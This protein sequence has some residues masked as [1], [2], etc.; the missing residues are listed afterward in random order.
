M[1][2][3]QA[4]KFNNWVIPFDNRSDAFNLPLRGS[5]IQPFRTDGGLSV[6]G[7]RRRPTAEKT[8][9]VTFDLKDTGQLIC[10]PTFN[11][12]ASPK[13][14]AMMEALLDGMGRL[15]FDN[16]AKSGPQVFSLAD[17]NEVSVT[18]HAD[19]WTRAVISIEWQVYNPIL[20]RP[21]NSG[22]ISGLGYTPIS[23]AD[24]DF[25]ESGDERVFAS[26]TVNS[27]PTNFTITNEGHFRTSNIIIR[28]ESL[29]AGGYD[30]IRVENTTTEQWVQFAR[31]AA[32]SSSVIQAKCSLGPHRVRESTDGGASFVDSP[33]SGNIWTD[34]TISDTQV[35]LMELIPGDNEIVVTSSGSPNC[36]VMFLWLPAYGMV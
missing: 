33:S 36:R 31:A 5:S 17:L 8:H 18:P 35:P 15:W 4:V 3:V 7:T 20:Y 22:Y 28:I 29:A 14:Q 26:F 27:S 1:P 13:F 25:G 9:T 19:D 12:S 32:G 11:Q 6:F 21:L 23:V 24:A 16:F 10:G 34:T 30:S 2:P